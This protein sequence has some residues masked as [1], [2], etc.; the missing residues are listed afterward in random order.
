MVITQTQELSTKSYSHQVALNHAP[1]IRIY[2]DLYGLHTVCIRPV[3]ANNLKNIR[4]YTQNIRSFQKNTVVVRKIYGR[5]QKYTVV[6]DRIQIN[7]LICIAHDVIFEHHH[8]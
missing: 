3:Y 6:Y 8:N 4:S 2:T 1:R 5:F 7:C